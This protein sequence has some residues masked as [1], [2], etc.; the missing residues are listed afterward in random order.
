MSS[1]NYNL[2]AY[3][4]KVLLVFYFTISICFNLEAQNLK[5]GDLIFQLSGN[6]EFSKAISE[7]T[8]CDGEL[9][10]SH[11]GIIFID[12]NNDKQVIEA[13]P[14]EGVRIIPLADFKKLALKIDGK[15][16]LLVKRLIVDID[17]NEAIKRAK[18]LIGEEYDWWFLPNND[19][20]YCSELVYE[21]FIDENGAHVFSSNPMNFRAKDGTMPLYWVQ[22]FGGKEENVPEGIEGTNP[23]DLS[24]DFRLMEVYR[25]F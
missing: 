21:S 15:P 7:A 3:Y 18:M 22:L 11:V 23:N 14:T 25:F 16:A 6:S 12:E 17:F 1:L 4:I 13:S 2:F 24:K 10:F 20:I 9:D 19:K 8:A 5:N